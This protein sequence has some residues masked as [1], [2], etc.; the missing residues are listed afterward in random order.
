MLGHK[1]ELKTLDTQC[2]ATNEITDANQLIQQFHVSGIIG[3]NQSAA[4]QGLIPTVQSDQIPFVAAGTLLQTSPWGITTFPPNANVANTLVGFLKQKFPKLRTLANMTGNT[5]FGLAVQ[6]DVQQYANQH[7]IQT[8][9]GQIS[10]TATDATP[11]LQ[12]V[13]GQSAYWS[14]TSGTINLIEAQNAQSLGWTKPL[15]FQDG[16]TSDLVPMQ[17]KYSN[18][19]VYGVS[20][21]AA[22]T[23]SL[24]IRR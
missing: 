15:L 11:S 16:L 22:L 10:N 5:P 20:P 23:L 6:Q 19:T 2:I 8:V 17:Q 14:N 4:I 3:G 12:P 24:T 13:A 9:Q 1:L 7:G 18:G 21:L